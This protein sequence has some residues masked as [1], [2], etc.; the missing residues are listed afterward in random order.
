M[1]EHRVGVVG[2]DDHQIRCAP[3]RHDVGQLD[4]AGLRHRAGIERRDL[5]HVLVGGADEPGGVGGVGH[6]HAVAV[7]AVAGEPA[8]VVVE[9]RADRADQHRVSAEHA[10][11]EGDVSRDAAAVDDQVVH[12][13]AQRDLLQVFGQQ[14]FGEPARKLHE[15]VGRDRSG[16]RDGHEAVTLQFI[17]LSR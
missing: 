2:A 6:Q 14:L 10:D 9:V 13:E 5:G 15:M 4:V 12:Q 16:Y 7:H 11:G 1:Q 3:S 17:N 8:R